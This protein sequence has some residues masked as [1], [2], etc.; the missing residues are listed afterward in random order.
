MLLPQSISKQNINKQLLELSKSSVNTLHQVSEKKNH[1]ESN[2][3]LIGCANFE[4]QTLSTQ[5]SFLVTLKSLKKIGTGIRMYRGV[6][7]W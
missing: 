1:F 4:P 6:G 2:K 5:K 3:S 7:I